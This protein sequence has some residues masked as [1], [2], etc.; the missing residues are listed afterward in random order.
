MPF[1]YEGRGKQKNNSAREIKTTPSFLFQ[2]DFPEQ[3][4]QLVH[5]SDIVGEILLEAGFL[6]GASGSEEQPGLCGR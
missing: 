2:F 6:R 5:Y 1:Q 3:R 4:Y